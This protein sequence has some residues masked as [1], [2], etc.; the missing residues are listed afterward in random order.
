MTQ[1]LDNYLVEKLNISS[2][3]KAQAL[4]SQGLVLVDGKNCKSSL[5]VDENN[6]IQILQYDE[7]VSRGAYKLLTAIQNFNLDIK[8]KVVLDIGASTGGFTQVALQN[9]AKKVYAV[10]VGIN[11]LHESLIKDNRVINLQGT[12]IRKLNISQV[13]DVNLIIGDLSFISLTHIIPV[14]IN[15]FGK[16]IHTMFLFKPQFEC[17]KDVAK[18]YKGIIKNKDIHKKLL[19]SF[20]NYCQSIQFNISNIVQS[21]IKGGDGN[22]EYLI[23]FNGQKQN[24]DINLIIDTAFTK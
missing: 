18:K 13:Q 22:I 4:I 7:Y 3:T 23:D 15:L 8:E 5:Q 19:Q 14:I 24:F 9:G 1:R 6:Q 11:Q 20:V 21:P 2:R 10:D 12:D 16:T 17:G